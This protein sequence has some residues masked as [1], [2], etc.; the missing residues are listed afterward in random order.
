MLL[1]ARSIDYNTAKIA[2]S[3]FRIVPRQLFSNQYWN[4]TDGEHVTESAKTF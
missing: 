2:K 1:C 3:V 4:V